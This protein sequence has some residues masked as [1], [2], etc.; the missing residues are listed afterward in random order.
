MPCSEKR[1]RLLLTKGRVRQGRVAVRANGSFNI[2][3][4]NSPV[5]GTS[6]VIAP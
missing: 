6:T 1:V 2:Q 4:S 3:I 5:Q